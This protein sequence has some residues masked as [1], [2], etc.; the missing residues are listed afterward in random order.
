MTLYCRGAQGPEVAEIQQKLKDEKIYNGPID[1]IYGGGTESAVC[2]F[3][4]ANALNPDGIAGATT[5]A[6]LFAG[7]A[8]AQTAIKE[9]E[10]KAQPLRLRCLALTGSFE[11]T[12]PPPDC[13]AGL[14]GDFDGQGLSF[15]VC[16]WNFGQNSLQPLLRE[17]AETQ[18]KL[19]DGI[20]HSY[21]DEFRKVI[22][23]SREEQLTWARSIQDARHSLVEPWLGLLKTLGRTPEFQAIE[24]SHASSLF[25]GALGLCR[26][27]G[28]TSQ[29]AAA[30]MFDIRVQNNSI[31]STVN[32]QI[33]RDFAALP[34]GESPETLEAKRLQIIATRRAQAASP[35]WAADVL[36]RKLTVANGAG[37]V[38]GMHYDLEA[39]YGITP[40]PFAP[41]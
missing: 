30:L 41:D 9:P 19:I 11:T 8:Q 34:A 10:I 20:F 15:G 38:H 17:L 32:A 23:V 25:D 6:K 7:A 27:Y 22:N 37:T 39:Q 3:Q 4:R 33:E 40:D 1:G 2:A 35:Q 13:F 14:S 5:W 16:Q 31:S 24:A 18:S 12:S 28:V 21:A 29:R 26:Q 36:N